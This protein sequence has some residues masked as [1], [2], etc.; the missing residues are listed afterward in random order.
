MCEAVS[1]SPGSGVPAES[2]SFCPQYMQKAGGSFGF[3][4]ERLRLQ[5]GQV[6]D[7]AGSRGRGEEEFARRERRLSGTDCET[8]EAAKDRA[9]PRLA[10]G[11]CR[12][13][14]LKPG[15]IRE[16]PRERA[17]IRDRSPVYGASSP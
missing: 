2:R 13:P 15:P 8:Q 17:S 4:A 16:K 1:M 12:R 10:D 7:I 5:R 9:G 3:A 11:G 6:T 14:G